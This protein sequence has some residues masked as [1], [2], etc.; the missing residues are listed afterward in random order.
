MELDAIFGVVGVFS[1][2]DDN[3][4]SKL[5]P[6]QE[7]SVIRQQSD[8][9]ASRGVCKNLKNAWQG[10]SPSSPGTQTSSYAVIGGIVSLHNKA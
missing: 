6:P 10:S 3:V 2:H 5:L 4:E 9:I 7:K 8:A 1:R